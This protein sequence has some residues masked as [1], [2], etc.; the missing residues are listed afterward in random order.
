MAPTALVG[1]YR[2]FQLPVESPNH[3]SPAAPA[4]G[5]VLHTNPDNVTASP[6]GWHDTDGMVGAES[7]LTTG[8]N[9]DAHKGATRTD[10]GASLIFDNPANFA[11][12]P[13]TFVPAAITNAFYLSNITR[14]TSSHCSAFGQQNKVLTCF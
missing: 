5:R 1:S 14:P 10:G 2:A 8:N 4:D 12:S 11:N 6:F 7:N 9:V 3:A 13:V